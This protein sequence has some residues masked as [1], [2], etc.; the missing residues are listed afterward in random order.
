MRILQCP[1]CTR[2]DGK[3]ALYRDEREVMQRC[4]WCLAL[5]VIVVGPRGVG[6]VAI[7]FDAKNP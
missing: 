5:L 4:P 6:E 7:L 3:D 1:E 2:R